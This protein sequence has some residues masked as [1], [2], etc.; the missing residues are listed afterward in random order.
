MTVL[1]DI[2]NQTGKETNAQIFVVDREM[3]TH[4]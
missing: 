4:G 3:T 1:Q 2:D